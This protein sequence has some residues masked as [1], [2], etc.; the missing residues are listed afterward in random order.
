MRDAA[1]DTTLPF[2]D[3]TPL[4]VALGAGVML[5]LLVATLDDRLALMSPVTD[6]TLEAMLMRRDRT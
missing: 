4:D 3:C 1:V 2:L 6:P 5:L